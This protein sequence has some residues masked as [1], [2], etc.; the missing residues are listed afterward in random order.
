M[1]GG[2]NDDDL[3]FLPIEQLTVIEI[4]LGFLAGQV[5][6]FIARSF[7]GPRIDIAQREQNL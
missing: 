4:L 5:R 1:V 7:Q 3:R 2:G 6:D